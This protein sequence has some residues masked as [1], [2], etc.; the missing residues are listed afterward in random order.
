MHLGRR[1]TGVVLVLMAISVGLV[2]AG[3][4]S[5]SGSRTLRL[6]YVTGPLHPYGLAL[7]QFAN[8][9]AQAS[10]GQL[11]IKLLPVYGGGNDLT[12]LN[13]EKG[14]TVDMGSV[15][16]AV[17]DTEGVKSF[18][19]LQMP[20]LISNYKIEAA[21]LKSPVERQMLAGT[22]KLGLH[23]L[24]I[25]EGGLRKPA[26]NG[27]CITTAT[28]FKGKKIRAVESDL[29]V[30]SLTALGANP[31]PLPLSDVYLALQNGTVKGMEANLGLIWTNK[32]Y[33]V[34]KCVTGNA[35]LWP[36]P[37]VLSMNN[38]TWKSLS[39]QQQQWITTAANRLPAESLAIVSDPKS[40]YV[41]ELCQK[42]IKFGTASK[43]GL[44]GML[45]KEQPVYQHFEHNAQVKNFVTAIQK[46]KAKTRPPA[47]SAPYPAGCAA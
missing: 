17:W 36:F 47:P 42:H 26:M 9:V 13:D 35:N 25:H 23:G 3:V 1:I 33:E 7:T 4:G 10:N 21:V 16:S 15:S 29:L 5:A 6:G 37:T 2:I 19:A 40:P 28:G 8:Q 43:S 39:S 44:A 22:S 20:F 46:I 14:G 32:Y 24:A 27:P 12:L 45:A 31:T 18:Q 11:K 38:H 30:R 41:S 34:L